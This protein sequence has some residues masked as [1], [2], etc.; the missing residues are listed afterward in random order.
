MDRLLYMEPVKIGEDRL[1]GILNATMEGV[2]TG[3]KRRQL[4]KEDLSDREAKYFK[5]TTCK[6]CNGTRINDRA[7]SVTINGKNIAELSTMELTD[8][9]D[10]LDGVSGPVADPILAPIRWRM[11][12]L[13]DIGAG[14]LSLDR[15]VGTLSGGE[16]QRVKMAKQLSCDLVSLIYVFDE[17]SV[18]LHPGDVHRVVEMLR[19]LRDRGNSI[20]VVEH[21]PDVIG[22]ADHVIDIG[23]GAGTKGGQV[24]FS[25]SVEELRRSDTPT[26]HMFTARAK[27]KYMRRQPSGYIEIRDACLHN[28]KHVNVRIPTGVMIAVTGVAG[29]GKS[30]LINDIF[31]GQHPEAVVVDQS[32]I[33]RS[34]RSNPA[35]Y[36]GAFD[37]IRKI[38]AKAN[39]MDPGLFSFN[40]AGACP[41]CGGLG[42]VEVE[43]H[44]LDSVRMTCT[45]CGGKRYTPAVLEMK[46]KGKSIADV[47]EMTVSDALGL[48]EGAVSDRTVGNGKKIRNRL[49]MLEKVGLGYLTLGQ[50]LSTLSGGE[51]QRIKLATE[52]D[53]NGN[54]YVM[55]EPTTGL[56]MAD[57][58]RL[59]GIIRS[60]VDAGNTVIVIEHNL[61][62]I[63][64]ADYVIDMGPEGGK[65]GGQVIAEGTPEDIAKTERSYTGRYLKELLIV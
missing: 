47:L 12:Q 11:Q 63:K 64:R 16:S 4:G 19:R 22:C 9:Q 54:V 43:M 39:G 8:L 38:F 14:Y 17:P 31:V 10:F 34:S 13:I 33:G 26:G 49:T 46:Y 62:V 40:S 23:P 24:L 55:D 44:F 6:A 36:V 65:K 45:E 29:S 28:L 41:K 32:A 57:V 60:L 50:P 15:P 48:F 18:G 59:M 61:D 27:E 21:D 2:V 42:Y 53:L 37:E 30:T 35:T 25:G 51:A 56:H 20:L 5:E 7:R 1:G 58:E 3:L 52:L